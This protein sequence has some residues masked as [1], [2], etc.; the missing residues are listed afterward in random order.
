MPQAVS[1]DCEFDGDMPTL[2][3]RVRSGAAL[4]YNGRPM[5]VPQA[6]VEGWRLLLPL[7]HR[8][9]TIDLSDAVLA[10]SSGNR[11][12]IRKTFVK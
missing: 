6:M 3:D 5:P 10:A 4:V 7:P 1:L 9:V 11:I 12:R 8:L 2:L